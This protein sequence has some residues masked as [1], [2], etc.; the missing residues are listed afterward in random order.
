MLDN[1]HYNHFCS[2]DLPHVI[3]HNMEPM[4]NER[5]LITWPLPPAKIGQHWKTSTSAS[6][7][8]EHQNFSYI[9]RSSSRS[10]CSSSAV[11]PSTSSTTGM[12]GMKYEE[13]CTSLQY[14]VDDLCSNGSS[15]YDFGGRVKA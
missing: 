9:S 13:Q 7:T 10:T 6:D 14:S 2:S 8:P 11:S 1:K 5:T 12:A 3:I 4:D 15:N